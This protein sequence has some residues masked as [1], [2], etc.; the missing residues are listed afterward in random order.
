[1]LRIVVASS[2]LLSLVLSDSEVPYQLRHRKRQFSTS[3]HAKYSIVDGCLNEVIE[4]LSSILQMRNKILDNNEEYRKNFRHRYEK[5]VKEASQ[6][7]N[8]TVDEFYKCCLAED[9][10]E[11]LEEKYFARVWQLSHRIKEL[12]DDLE[13][14][15]RRH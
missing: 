1:M 11:I 10:C 3:C 13:A 5:Q 2:L 7:C 8:P 14:E 15:F 6:R 9:S 4:D 12:Q